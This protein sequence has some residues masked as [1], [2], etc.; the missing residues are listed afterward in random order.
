M[1]EVVAP[2]RIGLALSGGGIRAAVFHLGVLRYLAERRLFEQVTQISTVSGGSLIIGAVFSHLDLKWPTSRQFLDVVYPALQARLTEGDLF[3]IRALGCKGVLRENYRIL[4]SRG[5]ILPRL[6]ERRWGVRG[7][8]KDLPDSPEWHINTTSFDTGK[9]W[10]FSKKVMGDWQFGR[11][12]SPDVPIAFAVAASAAVPYAIGALRL[13]LP[14]HGWWQT[15][16]ATKKPIQKNR[17]PSR[18][19]RLWDGGAYENMGLEAIYKPLEGLQGCDFLICS[20]ASGPLGA[21][22]S[23]PIAGILR[24]KLASPRLF[25]IASDQI[26]ALRSRMLM[27]SIG[28]GEVKGI[29]VKMGTSM[30]Q[31]GFADDVLAMMLTD[32]EAGSSLN[33]PTNL[34]KVAEPQFDIIAR[35]GS[36][37]CAAT[38][39]AYG[40]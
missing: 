31:F 39:K 13:D 8:V 21:P 15:D 1:D 19:V 34:T 26:R 36:E 17:P 27:G 30:R 25:D 10:R 24:G 9:N 6:L 4:F 18:R 2:R 20:D 5:Q 35:H 33:Y 16:P 14:E 12:Y 37:V 3:S 28:R 29:L 40:G 22:K 11:H 23:F 38:L 7:S 32:E